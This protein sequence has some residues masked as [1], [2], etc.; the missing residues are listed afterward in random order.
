MT[1]HTGLVAYAAHSIVTGLTITPVQTAANQKLPPGD[2][3]YLRPLIS[4]D[5]CLH[6]SNRWGSFWLVLR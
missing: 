1:G 3:S 6:V 4:A 2:R 5:P